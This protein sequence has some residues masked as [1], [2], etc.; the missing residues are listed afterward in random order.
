[1]AISRLKLSIQ[2]NPGHR[3]SDLVSEKLPKAAV[4]VILAPDTHEREL[5][6]LLVKR[7][8]SAE[9][10]WS[11]HMAFPGGRLKDGEDLLQTVRREVFEETSIDIQMH[12]FFGKLD[13][14]STGN[15][16]VMVSPFVFFASGQVN[17]TIETRELEDYVWIPM[18]FFSNKTNMQKMQV[19][20]LGIYHEVVSFPYRSSYVVWGMTLRIIDDLLRRM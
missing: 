6:A 3:R 20:M 4:G 15:R 1:M 16:S 10:P 2:T 7:K 9:D 11:G 12:E 5:T 8:K 17:A 14:Q 18:S 13:E 19:E